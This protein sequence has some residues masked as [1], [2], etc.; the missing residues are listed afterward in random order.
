[1]LYINED[2]M[3]YLLV[4]HFWYDKMLSSSVICNNYG[5]STDV[6]CSCNIYAILAL[7]HN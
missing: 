1:M 5:R 2:M 6:A 4:S 3:V 7:Q